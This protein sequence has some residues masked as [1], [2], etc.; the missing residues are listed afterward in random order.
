M[1]DEA[2]NALEFVAKVS[3]LTKVRSRNEPCQLA[4]QREHMPFRCS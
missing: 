1:E 4:A 2:P 3:A